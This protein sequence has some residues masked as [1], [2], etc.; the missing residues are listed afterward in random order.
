MCDFKPKVAR[1]TH[2]E[3]FVDSF[4]IVKIILCSLQD[5]AWNILCPEAFKDKQS[6]ADG[7]QGTR[8]VFVCA[9]ARLCCVSHKHL[10]VVSICVRVCVCVHRCVC[11]CVLEY[12]CVCVCVKLETI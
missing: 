4:S 5:I 9:C 12:V 6:S 8:C 1:S 11:V 2:F 3:C 10:C 7:L